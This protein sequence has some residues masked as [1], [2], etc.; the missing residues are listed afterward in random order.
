MLED[1]GLLGIFRTDFRARAAYAEGAGIYRIIPSA[2]AIPAHRDDLTRLV[3]WSRRTGTPLIPRGAGSGMCGGNVGSGAVVD[4]SALPRVLEVDPAQ[5]LARVS[6]NVTAGELNQRVMEHGL[7]LPPD[8][9]SAA[10]ASLGGMASTNAAGPLTLRYGSMRSWVHALEV[11][12]A[13]AEAGWSVRGSHQHGAEGPVAFQ[14]FAREAAPFLQE[15]ADLIRQR[16]PQTRKNSSGY[17]LDAWLDSHDPI[18]LWVGAEGTL[19]FISA[20]E[21]RLDSSPAARA[22]LQIALGDLDELGQVVATLLRL[23]PSAV[24]L[25][26][27]TFLEL[28][29]E[30]AGREGL[31]HVPPGTQAVLLV[32][33]EREDAAVARGA[34]GDA[35]R[36]A[37]PWALDLVTALDAEEERRVR[38]LRAAASPIVAGLSERRRSMQVIEDGC[39]PIDRLGTYI[40]FIRERGGRSASPGRDLRSRRGRQCAREPAP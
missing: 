10:W 33:F 29:A 36:L 19:G 2:V 15:A 30:S 27:R 32:D 38:A 14:R 31:R 37:G 12:T 11:V 9:S 40:R 39:V 22:V 16:F 18:D 13:D 8:P 25:L 23:R 20:L 4:L 21:I 1:P 17:A 34:V 35:A 6:P 26:D 5:R 3:Q 24:E 28:V 7:R